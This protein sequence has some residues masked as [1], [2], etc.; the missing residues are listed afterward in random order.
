MVI[1][2]N[3]VKKQIFT[4]Y[5]YDINVTIFKYSYYLEATTLKKTLIL[6]GK[7]NMVNVLKIHCTI[8]AKTTIMINLEC[9]PL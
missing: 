2:R 4:T 9:P 7:A 6:M 1:T 3:P 8:G 5:M